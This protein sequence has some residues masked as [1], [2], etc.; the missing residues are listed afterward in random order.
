MRRFGADPP[1]GRPERA[2]GVPFEGY[3]WRVVRPDG[4]VDVALAAVCRGWGMASVARHPGGLVRT[5][6]SRDAWADPGGFGVRIGDGFAGDARGVRADLGDG[7][8]LEVALRDSIPW[9]RRALGALGP[10]QLIP[11]LP[12]Y[13]QPVLLGA[14][15]EGGG[16]AY[17]EKNWARRFPDH[18]WWG[19]AGDEDVTVAFAGGRVGPVAPT[20]VVL[21]LGGRV[22]ALSPPAARTRIAMREGCWRLRTRGPRIRLE[23]EGEG[24]GTPHVLDVPVPAERRTEPRSH[25]HL[26]GRIALTVW[27]GARV[28]YRGELS[29]AGLERGVPRR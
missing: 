29:P 5:V 28:L 26:A 19:Q 17:A 21:R 7:A 22:L 24:G 18:W 3:Y 11:G 14:A 12:Q 15:V 16:S 25:Q 2:H 1:F 23:L 10:A 9:P 13:W 6:V 8:R 27:R 20:A 4:R